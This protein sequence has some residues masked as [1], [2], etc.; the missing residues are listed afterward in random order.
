MNKGVYIELVKIEEDKQ[1]DCINLCSE[2]EDCYSIKEL[3]LG[4]VKANGLKLSHVYMIIRNISNKRIT[5]YDSHFTA[6]D[7]SG[8][9]HKGC[10][11]LCRFYARRDNY[12]IYSYELHPGAKVKFLVLFNSDTISRIIYDG[13]DDIHYSLPIKEI[14]INESVGEVRQRFYAKSKEVDDL[15]KEIS[16]KDRLISEKDRLISE[17]REEIKDLNSRI[18]KLY[19]NHK[20]KVL[21][22]M[23]EDLLCKYEIVEDDKYYRI[24]SLEEYDTVSFNREF[25]KTKGNYNWINTNDALISLRVDNAYGYGMDG[26]TIIKSPVSGIFEFDNNKMI[27]YK[28]EI[29]RIKKY[30]QEMKMEVIA[31]LEK[32]DIKNAVYKKERKKMI[33][34]EVLDE[35]VQEGKIF[36]VYIQ[37][38]GNRM[39]IPMDIATAVWNRDGGKCCICGSNENLEF[40]HIIPISKGG[41][42]TFRNLQI[43]CKNCNIKKSDNI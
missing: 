35:L 15:K 22:R 4:T 2:N 10:E 14:K 13:S 32:E 38:D 30:P 28:E 21:Q 19:E 20:E 18:N 43:L 1:L 29:C 3:K 23:R 34:R 42:T 12:E 31:G 25:D 41:A 6:I 9:S 24:F 37:K 36:N 33:E 26:R 5:I 8:F 40:D 16:Q 7:N 11:M 17:L 27:K 39:T